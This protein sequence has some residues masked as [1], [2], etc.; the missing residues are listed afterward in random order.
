MKFEVAFIKKQMKY[1][2]SPRIFSKYSEIDSATIATVAKKQ[3]AINNFSRHVRRC[4]HEDDSL[5][6]YKNDKKLL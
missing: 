2:R 4:Q 5:N 6:T 3:S 1:L